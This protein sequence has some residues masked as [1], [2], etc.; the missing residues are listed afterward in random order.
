MNFLFILTFFFQPGLYAIVNTQ[1]NKCYVGE[2]GNLAERLSK[3]FIQ[4]N[5]Q[6]FQK[7]DCMELQ[8]D[9]E[10]YGKQAFHFGILEIGAVKWSDRIKRLKLERQYIQK[11]Q[12]NIYNKMSIR[13][14]QNISK[15]SNRPNSIPI[16]VENEIF[17]SISEAS[18][19]FGVSLSTIRSRLNNL[20]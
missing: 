7:H 18:R 3:H 13:E 2:A 10:F 1:T 6:N 15:I 11:Y 16:S 4:L 9:W 8:K 17:S 20:K 5:F 19:F 14:I 12:E